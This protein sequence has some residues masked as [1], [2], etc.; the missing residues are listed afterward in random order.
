MTC[1]SDN[2]GQSLDEYR[3]RLKSTNMRAWLF[4]YLRNTYYSFRVEKANRE[5]AEV[6]LFTESLAD[7][8]RPTTA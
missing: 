3:G 1:V 5:V 8:A 7:K 6:R 2:F 4:T